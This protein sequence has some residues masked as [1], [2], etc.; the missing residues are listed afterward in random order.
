MEKQSSIL[1]PTCTIQD[2]SNQINTTCEKHG[3]LYKLGTLIPYAIDVSPC[4]DTIIQNNPNFKNHDL[5]H[6]NLGHIN[7]Q[8]MK[9]M[10]ANNYVNNGVQ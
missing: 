2:K 4:I 8:K 5:W 7:V 9:L 6:K 1:S 3:N 10:H